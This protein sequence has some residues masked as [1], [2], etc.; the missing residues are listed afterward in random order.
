M[1][2]SESDI[3]SDALAGIRTLAAGGNIH[4]TRHALGEMTNRRILLEE[5]TA[6]IANGE[7]LENYPEHQRGP[8]CLVNGTTAAG[9]PLHVVCTTAQPTLIIITVYEPRMPKWKSPR[10]RNR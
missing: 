9:S 5:L 2:D 7:I 10:E 1:D 3:G 6:A 4:V 8:C